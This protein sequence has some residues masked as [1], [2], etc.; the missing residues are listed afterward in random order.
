MTFWFMP[1]VRSITGP[2]RER[3]L[4]QLAT[5]P[6][7]ETRPLVGGGAGESNGSASFVGGCLEIGSLVHAAF[8][9]AEPIPEIFLEPGGVL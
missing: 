5:T 4:P 9:F 6:S 3:A 1:A 8:E 2:G 7:G